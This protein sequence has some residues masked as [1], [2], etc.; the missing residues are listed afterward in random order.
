MQLGPLRWLRGR[1]LM[2]VQELQWVILQEAA[3]TEPKLRGVRVPRQRRGAFG[4]YRRK[5]PQPDLSTGAHNLVPEGT[6]L[7]C[8]HCHRRMAARRTPRQ[9]R[10][11][12]CVRRQRRTF[13]NAAVSSHDIWTTETR[14][15]CRQC[16][17][18]MQRRDRARLLGSTCK[19]LAGP[20][21]GPA[22]RAQG[23]APPAGVQQLTVAGASQ[24]RGAKRSWG[25]ADI[26]AWAV[27]STPAASELPKGGLEGPENRS[28]RRALVGD[29]EPVSEGARPPAAPQASSSSAVPTALCHSAMAVGVQGIRRGLEGPADLGVG[30]GATVGVLLF[31]SEGASSLPF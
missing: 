20:R 18:N 8:T 7:K 11:I 2:R 26:R 5:G 14:V 25:S 19:G 6:W 16:G 12:P 24:R 4:P 3:K 17:R 31:P 1:W 9:W 10:S 28:E 27:R 23:G 13:L 22:E 21:A 15:G 30:R 29:C